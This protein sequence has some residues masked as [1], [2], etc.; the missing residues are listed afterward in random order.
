MNYYQSGI[1]VNPLYSADQYAGAMRSFQQPQRFQTGQLPSY[2]QGMGAPAMGALNQA[3]SYQ[4]NAANRQ[5]GTNFARQYAGMNTNWLNNAEQGRANMGL[6]NASWA[7][8]NQGRLYDQQQQMLGGLM[9]LLSPM[10]MG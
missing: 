5:A 1:D 4:G 8:Q 9:R 7:L 10:L 3:L 6:Q 2:F